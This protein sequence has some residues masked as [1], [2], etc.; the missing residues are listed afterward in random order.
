M[1]NISQKLPE[2]DEDS[3]TDAF[4]EIDNLTC[5]LSA[6]ESEP[7]EVV[8]PD[9]GA[10][11]LTP[12]TGPRIHSI[13]SCDSFDDIA[14]KPEWEEIFSQQNTLIEQFVESVDVSTCFIAC[15]YGHFILT[16]FLFFS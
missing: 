4:N 8:M 14:D 11:F 13:F 10:D 3:I 6:S 7:V 2:L 5:L 15:F 16:S 12:I 9:T 1:S